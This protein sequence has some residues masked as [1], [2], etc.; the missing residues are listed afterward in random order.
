MAQSPA[1]QLTSDSANTLN[2]IGVDARNGWSRNGRRCL[3][4]PSGQQYYT[5]CAEH[6]INQ[7]QFCLLI[8]SKSVARTAMRRGRG[9]RSRDPKKCTA[10]LINLQ[11]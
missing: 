7:F 9:N 10:M 4:S 1:D 2:S 6:S 11:L 8:G 5:A 3:V